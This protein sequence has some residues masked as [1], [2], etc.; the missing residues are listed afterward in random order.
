MSSPVNIEDLAIRLARLEDERAIL[1]TLYRYGHALDYGHE[2]DWVDGFTTDGVFDVR[3]RN[4]ELFVRCEGREQLLTFAQEH[5]RPPAAYH[6]HFV[7]DPL[8]ELKGDT[9]HVDSYF[10]RIDADDAGGH[11]YVIAMGR[12]RDDLVR[13]PDGVWRIRLRLAEI[14]D[15]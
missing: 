1:Q 9:A 8:I 12:Y 13:C 2:D 10:A 7:V 15:R 4:G 3:N 6:K 11:A 14:Q 5:T